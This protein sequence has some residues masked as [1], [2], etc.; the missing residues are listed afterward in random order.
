MLMESSTCPHCGAP[1]F[2]VSGVPVSTCKCGKVSQAGPPPGGNPW[3][4]F[5]KDNTMDSYQ[6]LKELVAEQCTTDSGLLDSWGK[7]C[8]ARAIELM[9]VRGDV[10]ITGKK[11]PKVQA[12]WL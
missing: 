2:D 10:K 9:H 3:N 11:G 7:M 4:N 12:E 1:I 8:Y 6:I 5:E